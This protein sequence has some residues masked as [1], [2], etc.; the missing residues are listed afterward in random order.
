MAHAAGPAALILRNITPPEPTRRRENLRPEVYRACEIQ[1]NNTTFRDSRGY[2]NSMWSRTVSPIQRLY[3]RLRTCRELRLVLPP[4]TSHNG[5]SLGSRPK[6]LIE[7]V[8]SSGTLSHMKRT[9]YR[10]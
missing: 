2:T 1:R 4:I 5:R 3:R 7:V 10:K 9:L 8:C 6:P